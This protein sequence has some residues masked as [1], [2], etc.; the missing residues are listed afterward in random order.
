M[1]GVLE[2]KQVQNHGTKRLLL[3]GNCYVSYKYAVSK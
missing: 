1:G 3:Q 2:D